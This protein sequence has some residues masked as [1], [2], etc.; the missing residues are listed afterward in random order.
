MTEGCHECSADALATER[1]VEHRCGRMD[2][3]SGFE[4][5]CPKC[6]GP[7]DESTFEAVDVVERCTVCGHW[8]APAPSGDSAPVDVTFP[9]LPALGESLTWLPAWLVPSS[10]RRRQ[11]LSSAILVVVL[12]AGVAGA[13]ATSPL[14]EETPDAAEVNTD[15]G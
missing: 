6:G 1:V 13:L 5:G 14:L 4:D 7:I 11:L 8:Q 12:T 10:E 9:D 15:P 3:R 2:A